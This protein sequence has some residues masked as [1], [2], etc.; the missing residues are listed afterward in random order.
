MK[1]QKIEPILA[2][3]TTCGCHLCEQAEALLQHWVTRID[4]I[5]I[6]DDAEL[7]DRYGVRIPVLRRIDNGKELDWP[8]DTAGIE[9]LLAG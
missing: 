8:F 7:L 9:D 4:M 1:F 5:E 6:A 2:L 3:Y